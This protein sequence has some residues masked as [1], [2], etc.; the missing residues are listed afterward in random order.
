MVFCLLTQL[1]RSI[2]TWRQRNETRHF[3]IGVVGWVNLY[4]H[5]E[6]T[7]ARGVAMVDTPLASLAWK[8]DREVEEVATRP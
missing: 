3:A 5:N 6:E 7:S 4:M 2:P 1:A 8:V